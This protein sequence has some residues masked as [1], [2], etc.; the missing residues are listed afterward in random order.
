MF[1]DVVIFD[2]IKKIGNTVKTV[3][4]LIRF[5]KKIKIFKFY[6]ILIY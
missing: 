1:G 3:F 2:T 4:F 6:V 5:K